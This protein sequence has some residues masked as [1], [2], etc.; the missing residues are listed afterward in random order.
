MMRVNTQG[1][2]VCAMH[3]SQIPP[4]RTVSSPTT[5]TSNLFDPAQPADRTAGSVSRGRGDVACARHDA[6]PAT[7]VMEL[8]QR[9]FSTGHLPS[10]ARNTIRQCWQP[11]ILC[12]PQGQR[13]K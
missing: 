5:D 1:Q 11:R 10:P 8:L 13:I 6:P 7:P 2:G 4:G 12:D 3:H 9:A